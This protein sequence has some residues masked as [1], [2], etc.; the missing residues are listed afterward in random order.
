M[1]D[2]QD[3]GAVTLEFMPPHIK[4]LRCKRLQSVDFESEDK[5]DIDPDELVRTET[6]QCLLG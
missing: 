3:I 6:K 5:G 1:N 2:D 4:T